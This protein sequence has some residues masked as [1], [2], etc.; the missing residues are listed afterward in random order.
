M[1]SAANERE[2][3]KANALVAAW[4]ARYGTAPTLSAV[5]L[6]LSV[7][8]LET[9]A[10]DFR[11]SHNWGQIMRRV[12]TPQ[13]K[14]DL[15]AGKKLTPRDAREILSSDT[16][17]NADGSI[18][19]YP[20]WLW[21]FPDDVAGADKLLSV[22]LDA[23]PTIKRAIDTMSF[24]DLASEMYDTNYYEG[25][26]PKTAPGGPAANKAAYAANLRKQDVAARLAGW[27]APS[28]SPPPVIAVVAPAIDPQEAPTP[29]APVVDEADPAASVPVVP[30][31]AAPSPAFGVTRVAALAAGLLLA[32]GAAL[33]WCHS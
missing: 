27:I 12:L 26:K 2:E 19:T 31:A 15:A 16:L 11:G 28:A 6:V 13:E 4:R 22:L 21:A 25:S 5:I 30:S 29:A 10:G 9:N 33:A 17:P 23:R 14:A 24:E 7:A 3:S 8:E 1:T 18:T 20:I 32:A